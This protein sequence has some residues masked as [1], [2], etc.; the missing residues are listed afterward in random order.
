MVLK[1]KINNSLQKIILKISL[2]IVVMLIVA[3][4]SWRSDGRGYMP[5]YA[6]TI[7]IEMLLKDSAFLFETG[8]HHK[9]YDIDLV[10]RHNKKYQYSHLPI[11]IKMIVDD[12]AYAIDTVS[13]TLAMKNEHAKEY[14][15]WLGNGFAD[16]ISLTVP[17]REKITIKE[18]AKV[19]L[20]VK[21]LMP[22]KYA[23]G[24]HFI[25]ISVTNALYPSEK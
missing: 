21:P 22:D 23:T 11:V 18:Y 3:G 9:Q 2:L 15:Q 19:K 24:I 12:K 17:Y 1:Q 14:E 7:P 6:K 13:L 8:H 10:V 16:Y 5:K 20:L 4:C 25:G